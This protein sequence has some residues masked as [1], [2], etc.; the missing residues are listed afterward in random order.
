MDLQ[1]VIL[2]QATLIDELRAENTAL[3]AEIA[4]LKKNSTTSSKPPSSDIVKPKPK[5]KKGKKKRKRGAQPGHKQHL[6]K[7]LAPEMIDEIVK[8]DLSACPDCNSKLKLIDGETKTFQQ[9]EL[10]EKPIFVTE[11]HQLKYWCEKC[12][13]YHYARLPEDVAKEGLFGKN[14]TVLTAYLKG[15]GHMSYRTLKDYFHDVLGFDISTGFLV[16]QINNVSVALKPSYDALAEFLKQ[17]EHLYIDET[18]LKK[19]GKLQ[20][21]WCFVSDFFTF[22]K[23]DASRGSKVLKETLGDD[24]LG[25]ISSDFFSAYRKYAKD[26]KTLVQFCWAHLIREIKFLATLDDTQAYGKR[27]LKHVKKMF[28]TIHSHDDLMEDEFK[29]LMLQHKEAILNTVRQFVPEHKKA[30]VLAE[31]FEKFG[32]S[33]FLFIDHSGMEPTNN[34]AEREIRTLVI[35]RRITQGVRSQA[36]NEWHERFW[37]VLA[38]CK[39]QGKNV[40]AFLRDA[41]HSLLHGLSPPSLVPIPSEG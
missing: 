2:E 13:C 28:A 38:T 22:F 19:N 26:T 4:A 25:S 35:D 39:R 23:V 36:G 3:K 21:V 14:M 12:Q 40:M 32:E 17:Q 10:V 33:Y 18:S 8:L 16:G 31:R 1:Q 41:I 30:M 37:T 29:R 27:L 20:W 6:R 24:F 7:P 5:D 34:A 11:Y 9:I 15:K